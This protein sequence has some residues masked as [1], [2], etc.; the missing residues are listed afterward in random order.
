MDSDGDSDLIWTASNGYLAIQWNLANVTGIVDNAAAPARVEVSLFPNPVSQQVTV[1]AGR[2][3]VLR[4]YDVLGC[5]VKPSTRIVSG[6]NKIE[7]N[8]PKQIYFFQF[9]F[10]NQKPQ[11]KKVLLQ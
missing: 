3:G 8:L 11:V 5:Q 7:L 6:Q 2:E 1:Q 4:I 9:I 10:P